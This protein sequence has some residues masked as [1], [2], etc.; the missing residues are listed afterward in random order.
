MADT[1]GKRAS[2]AG[3]MN[4]VRGGARVCG[5]RRN[6]ACGGWLASQI[7]WYLIE[8]A[9]VNGVGGVRGGRRASYWAKWYWFCTING[10]KTGKASQIGLFGAQY[11]D[12]N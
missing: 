7:G 12:L 5:F 8:F 9:G 10:A 6:F 11:T 4:G 2:G 1:R 3:G